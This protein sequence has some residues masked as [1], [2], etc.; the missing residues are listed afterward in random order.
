MRSRLALAVAAASVAVAGAV[1]MLGAGPANSA[2]RGTVNVFYPGSMVNLNEQHVGPAFQQ[3]TGYQYQGRAAGSLAIVSE[4]KSGLF[5][6]DVVELADP[7][8]N[9]LLMGRR[10]YLSWYVTMARGQLVIGFDPRSKYA[11][12]LRAAQHHHLAWYRALL[13][14]GLR[15]GRT[16]PRLDPKGYR[17]LFMAG[18]AQRLYH[19]PHL[20][21]RL[22]GTPENVSQIFPE[23]VLAARL[24]TGQ[25][26]AAILYLSEARDLHIPY[27]S[28]PARINLGSPRYTRLYATQHFHPSGSVDVTGSPILY[29]VSIARRPAN[30]AGARAFVAFLL[31]KRGRSL[32]R[33]HG[34]LPA[35]PSLH[36]RAP[37]SIRRLIRAR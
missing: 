27:I 24:Q 28:L 13:Q 25:L 5:R 8:V 9:K 17:T 21:R 30:E 37:P 33:A 16:D 19:K 10:G 3:K 12:K 20:E 6:P 14:P 18:L 7:A 4:I 36:G 22:L 26:D 1:V 2:S 11:A 23:E 32:S 15:L 34:F 35:E 29:T 31:S